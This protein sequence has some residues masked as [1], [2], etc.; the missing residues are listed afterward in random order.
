M[1]NQKILCWCDESE[2]IV[3][4][5][6]DL[7]CECKLSHLKSAGRYQFFFD[8]LT[9]FGMI[10]GPVSSG[11]LALTLCDYFADNTLLDQTI[12]GICVLSGA[13]VAMVKY[14]GISTKVEQN[15]NVASLYADIETNTLQHIALNRGSR[16]S[17]VTYIPYLRKKLE[18]I[19]GM[20]PDV[21]G[22]KIKTKHAKCCNVHDCDIETG[23]ASS[24]TEPSAPKYEQCCI[25][26][27]ECELVANSSKK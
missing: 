6:S 13:A 8:K 1:S 27:A 9:T 18:N 10:A 4:D 20:S 11:L 2:K 23:N 25:Q 5:I 26:L 16:I 21:L 14:S 24:S 3:K 15:K 12:T 19:A 7:S 17:A 22:K